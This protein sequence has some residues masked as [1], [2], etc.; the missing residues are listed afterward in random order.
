MQIGEVIFISAIVPITDGRVKPRLSR[1]DDETSFFAA[2]FNHVSIN[3][4]D[5]AENSYSGSNL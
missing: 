5:F 3:K 1:F 2:T 4:G